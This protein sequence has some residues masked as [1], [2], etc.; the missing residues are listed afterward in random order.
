METQLRGQNKPQEGN[1]ASLKGHSDELV[2]GMIAGASHIDHAD[3]LRSGA[4][5]AV[6]GHRVM[7]PSTLGS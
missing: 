2:H 4:T 5:G 3:M 1:G 7:A 6:L